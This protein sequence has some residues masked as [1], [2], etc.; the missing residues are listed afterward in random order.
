MLIIYMFTWIQN[1]HCMY[2]VANKQPGC[3]GEVYTKGVSYS[4]SYIIQ[5]VASTKQFV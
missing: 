5:Y 2:V 3:V 1:E 4:I